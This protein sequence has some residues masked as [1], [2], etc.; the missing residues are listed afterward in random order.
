M[1]NKLIQ[2]K[3]DYAEAD[4]ASVVGN[5]VNVYNTYANALT[6]GEDGLVTIYDFTTLTGAIGDAITQVAKTTGVTVDNNG[7]ASFYVDDGEYSEVF[8][9][10]EMGRDSTPQRVVVQ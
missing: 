8:L 3:M 2:T 10:S 5:V 6:H 4:G 1:A 7:L 9:I